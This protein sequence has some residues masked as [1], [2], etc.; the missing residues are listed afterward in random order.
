M[1]EHLASLCLALGIFSVG[2]I[3]IGPN[4]LAVIG[5]SME[6]G[7][8]QGAAL[9]LGVGI[10]S[11]LWATLTVAG[12]S[13][14]MTAYAGA[15]VALKIIGAAYLMWLAWKAFRSAATRDSD[16]VTEAAQGDNLFWRGLSV[17]MTNPKAALHWIAIVS[18]GLGPEAPAWLGVALVL[19]ATALSVLGHLAY[20][21]TFSTRPVVA[22]YCR[23][24]RWISGILGMFFTIAAVK[25]ITDRS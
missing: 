16:I 11:G 21:V 3:S 5:T 14:L 9:A 23:A 22:F 17:Q 8:R 19:S 18:I 4:I 10:G 1:S 6:R 20:A 12:L 24:R 15:M 25:L 7:R 2:F 13:A